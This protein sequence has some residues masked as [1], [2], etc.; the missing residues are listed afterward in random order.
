MW[1][2][3]SLWIRT[4]TG[5]AL[6]QSIYEL[7]IMAGEHR[8]FWNAAATFQRRLA[9]TIGRRVEEYGGLTEEDIQ[10]EVNA[11]RAKRYGK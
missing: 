9:R 10:K 11:V 6:E 5:L 7:T 8:T 1:K 2:S 4:Q 3:D